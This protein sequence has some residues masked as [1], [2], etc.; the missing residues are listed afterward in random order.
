MSEFAAASPAPSSPRGALPPGCRVVW[1][2]RTRVWGARYLAGGAPWGLV[3]LA[4]PART[5]ATQL[6]GAGTRGLVPSTA[7]EQALA[8]GL[9]DRGL[10][11]PAPPPR[12]PVGEC[13]VVVPAY[14]RP[15]LLDR[16]LRQLDG[17][18][19]LVVDDASPDAEAVRRV[20][21]AHGARL[22]RHADN[23]GPGAARNTGLAAT[24]APLV[25]FL[26]SDCVA[27]SGWL[28]G[29]V[30]YLDDPRVAI[31]APRVVPHA[32]VGSLLAR[33]EA[34]R[35]ALDMGER[36][37][38]VRHGARL[39]FL[40][41]AALLVRRAALPPDGFASGLRVGEDV[42]LVWRVLDAGWH[43]RYEP[44]VIVEHELRRDPREWALRRFQYG[45]SAAGLDRRHPGRLAPARASAWNTAVAGLLVARR[46]LGAGL[47][48]VATV[49][50]LAR[51]LRRSG[52][53]PQ[54]A[55]RVVGKGLVA[56]AAGVGQALRREWWPLGWL[57][58]A[59][60]CRG[61]TWGVAAAVS[62][63]APLVLEYVRHRPPLDPVRYGL[64]RLVE[65]AVYGCG[66]L[67]SA[68]RGRRPAALLPRLRWP[69]SA[70]RLHVNPAAM[71]AARRANTGRGP[72][73]R[74]R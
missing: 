66:V 21:A 40:P 39:G 4:L 41:S 67:A 63:L 56:D 20:V 37:E 73:S 28:E 36:S 35:S 24:D 13:T 70:S 51:G 54:L 60:A 53:P 49:G 32:P 44:A 1:D 57:G 8:R 58:L 59:R 52:V 38:L 17:L 30:G 27:P 62:M 3:R 64:L 61:S 68:F 6:R 47:L 5:F 33:H 19:V 12:S 9:V 42:D 23:R 2:D 69:G 72:R 15:Q 22:V 25:A 14:G 55:A 10:A 71:P 34:T 46:P 11:H 18:D 43:V 29:L 45:T 26:D 31:V 50:A 74:R 16:C 7:T 65:D 48:A